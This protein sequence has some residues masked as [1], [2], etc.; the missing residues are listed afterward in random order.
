MPNAPQSMGISLVETIR[1]DILAARLTP[2]TKL[3]VKMLSDIY[4]CGASPVREALNRLTSEGLVDRIDRRGF[5]VSGISADDLADILFN[6]C[7]LEGEALR[8]SIARGGAE[9]EEAVLISH[10]RL[11]VLPRQIEEGAGPRPNPVWEVAHKRFHMALLSACGSRLLLESCERLHELNNRYRHFSRIAGGPVRSIETEH[12]RLCDL[13]LARR[14]EDAVQAL[15]E[16]YQRT[17]DAVLK[18]RIETRPEA[19]GTPAERPHFPPTDGANA[20]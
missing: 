3:T 6:R 9:W 19:H 10:Y 4:D 5:F 18:A 7:L 12:R 17:G 2:G 8:R 1:G 11:S 15:T 13:V 20:L 14:A 16:H